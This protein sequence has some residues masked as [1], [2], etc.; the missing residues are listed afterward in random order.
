MPIVTGIQAEQPARVSEPNVKPSVVDNYE[1]RKNRRILRQGL[2]QAVVQSPI[3]AGLGYT[4]KQEAL[5]LVK[6]VATDLIN[7]VENG[8]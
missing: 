6:E 2:V 1:D 8:L 3:L 5:A 7:F 4:N